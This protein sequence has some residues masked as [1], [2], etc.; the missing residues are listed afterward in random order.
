MDQSEV[1]VAQ[2]ERQIPPELPVNVAVRLEAGQ[3]VRRMDG[4]ESDGVG[5]HS[6]RPSL[7]IQ[8]AVVRRSSALSFSPAPCSLYG[9]MKGV[10]LLRRN[11][12]SL[13]TD[14]KL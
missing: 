7:Q 4:G 3:T 11:K 6:S 1:P 9:A 5:R 8:Q 10:T 13:C 2:S 12:G 14:R